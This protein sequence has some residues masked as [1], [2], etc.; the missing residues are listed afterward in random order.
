MHEIQEE[1]LHGRQALVAGIV[2]SAAIAA[3]VFLFSGINLVRQQM[4]ISR[5]TKMGE[6]F[7]AENRESLIKFFGE[8]MDLCSRQYAD[9]VARANEKG[10]Y[11]PSSITCQE[12]TAAI[13]S[14]KKDA[15][16]DFSATVFVRVQPQGLELVE[17]SGKY[18]GT[19]SYSAVRN[20]GDLRQLLLDGK[21]TGQWKD[22]LY[23]L[24]RK[25]VVVTIKDGNQT[26]GYLFMSVIEK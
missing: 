11:R 15:L 17:A 7:A 2:L 12:S 19:S 3:M 5:Y 13:D 23:E 20:E 1:S 22:F 6:K 18:H 26:L 21:V 8:T 24:P 9:S 25:E 16:T 14:F 10:D 4:V